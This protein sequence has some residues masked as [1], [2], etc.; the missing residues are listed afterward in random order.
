[1]IRPEV[2]ANVRIMLLEGDL[3]CLC[4]MRSPFLL[5]SGAGSNEF[6]LIA[7]HE[8]Q[9]VDHGATIRVTTLSR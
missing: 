3:V 7:S 8:K 2:K 1:M 6:L 9:N 4:D 5:A